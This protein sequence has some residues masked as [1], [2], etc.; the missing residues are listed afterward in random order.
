MEIKA[1]ILIWF[2]IQFSDC[3]VLIKSLLN[4]QTESISRFK[5]SSVAGNSTLSTNSTTTN[6][7]KDINSLVNNLINR[8]Y[9]KDEKQIHF[10]TPRISTDKWIP[11][12]DNNSSSLT[13]ESSN[14]GLIRINEKFEKFDPIL[15]SASDHLLTKNYNG[16][17]REDSVATKKDPQVQYDEHEAL[18]SLNEL[19]KKLKN[20]LELLENHKKIYNQQIP[21]SI[22]TTANNLPANQQQQLQLPPKYPTVQ[23]E[24]LDN[25]ENSFTSFRSLSNENNNSLPHYSL[26]YNQQ[27][28]RIRIN[29]DNHLQDVY[30]KINFTPK[31]YSTP[32]NQANHYS[33]YQN[34]QISSTESYFK[35]LPIESVNLN[36]LIQQQQQQRIAKPAEVFYLEKDEFNSEI[37]PTSILPTLTPAEHQ[38]IQKLTNNNNTISQDHYTN[39]FLPT[40]QPP[41][42]IPTTFATSQ[43]SD[44]HY[45][46]VH[47]HLQSNLISTS[48]LPSTTN[49]QSNQFRNFQNNQLQP[50]LY[51]PIMN[52][53]S[54]PTATPLSYPTVNPL[55]SINTI[56]SNPSFNSILY[57]KQT[58]FPANEFNSRLPFNQGFSS[59]Y[60]TTARTNIP[61]GIQS[62]MQPPNILSSVSSTYL[63]PV[64]NT[65]TIRIPNESFS[66]HPHHLY[67]NTIPNLNNNNNVKILESGSHLNQ[68]NMNPQFLPNKQQQNYAFMDQTIKE[69]DLK[70]ESNPDQI[71]FNLN[72]EDKNNYIILPDPNL[73]NLQSAPVSFRNTHQFNSAISSSPMN[74]LNSNEL[75]NGKLNNNAPLHLMNMKNPSPPTNPDYV[76]VYDEKSNEMYYIKTNDFNHIKSTNPK[77]DL[78]NMH[79]PN[80][81]YYESSEATRELLKAVEA[82]KMAVIKVKPLKSMA[83]RAV[84]DLA[85]KLKD[86]L[87]SFAGSYS[88]FPY[89]DLSE[90]NYNMK[91]DPMR[92]HL[93]FDEYTG[94]MLNSNAMV[95]KESSSLFNTLKTGTYAKPDFLA[96]QND[97]LHL[98]EPISLN[99]DR[100]TVKQNLTFGNYFGSN[101]SY[102]N[103]LSR[104]SIIGNSNQ[105]ANFINNKQ[106]IDHFNRLIDEQ[107]R[108][109]QQKQSINVNP[110]QS[111]TPIFNL[112]TTNSFMKSGGQ[113]KY[114]NKYITKIAIKPNR[115][116]IV[117]HYKYVQSYKQPI[118]SNSEPL[119]ISNNNH[120][121]LN[122]QINYWHSPINEPLSSSTIPL[123]LPRPNPPI[124]KSPNYRYPTTNQPINYHSNNNPNDQ[125]LIV[126]ESKHQVTY[127]TQPSPLSDLNLTDYSLFPN[128]F[129]RL[130][131]FNNDAVNFSQ[132]KKN[133]TS[134]SMMEMRTTK[135]RPIKL[136][137]NA[138][139]RKN[140]TIAN[141]NIIKLPEFNFQYNSRFSPSVK[142]LKKNRNQDKDVTR[143]ERKKVRLR[144]KKENLM[145]EDE[146]E[147]D[148]YLP[149]MQDYSS[150]NN[151]LNQNLLHQFF[152][153]QPTSFNNSSLLSFGEPT[154]AFDA[155]S[156][157]F[158]PFTSSITPTSESN[159]FFD[160]MIDIHNPTATLSNGLS[161]SLS[162]S[163]SNTML[164]NNHHPSIK[165]TIASLP[166]L[167]Q[168]SID[169]LQTG[170]QSSLPFT[171]SSIKTPNLFLTNNEQKLNQVF[172]TN[173]KQGQ[174]INNNQNHQQQ[175]QQKNNSVNKNKLDYKSS[176]TVPLINNLEFL[177]PIKNRL[178]KTFKDVYQRLIDGQKK[179]RNQVNPLNH[180][181]ASSFSSSNDDNEPFFKVLEL[182]E[183]N[184]RDVLNGD[185]DADLLVDLLAEEK[186]QKRFH[187]NSNI[188][189]DEVFG[190][191]KRSLNTGDASMND[192]NLEEKSIELSKE[193]DNEQRQMTDHERIKLKKSVFEDLLRRFYENSENQLKLSK[194]TS[195]DNQTNLSIKN[196][197][198]QSTLAHSIDDS[199]AAD[200]TQSIINNINYKQQ[201]IDY[202]NKESNENGKNRNQFSNLKQHLNES[203]ESNGLKSIIDEN[204]N[205]NESNSRFAKLSALN[206]LFNRTINDDEH[207]PKEKALREKT[208]IEVYERGKKLS[209]FS[210]YYF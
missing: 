83:T 194:L 128:D 33:N 141:S 150:L 189:Q 59:Y 134:K 196:S 5:R 146:E 183:K 82:V 168:S 60:P 125:P 92:T 144:N 119:N 135:T 161:N 78:L 205:K 186:G 89:S 188:V 172:Q 35:N 71:Q 3:S 197:T 112:S 104:Q 63:P 57:P 130:N 210:N 155:P 159:W 136:T 100:N 21:T 118:N 54:F 102:V 2:L 124:N 93:H 162:N 37:I 12:L 13:D 88:S 34:N 177:S 39:T 95:D 84:S 53:N 163:L 193:V 149:K 77:L 49:L 17:R 110:T 73:P 68:L 204:L 203:N 153:E 64:Q 80:K 178:Q 147:K 105:T 31:I 175:Q 26:E 81:D 151:F 202:F 76:K 127:T 139:Q 176:A 170:L 42:D 29:A 90:F 87:K 19:E 70:S 200:S 62:T 209:F 173:N 38:L 195:I 107:K 28:G 18:L 182:N 91:L 133:V 85:S 43:P 165:Y 40:Y 181:Q 55:N 166:I 47:N 65:T 94:K 24:N 179:S 117:Q 75:V 120:T 114:I 23:Y 16:F 167:H 44:D 137:S 160:Q 158:T 67:A 171:Y 51:R 50:Y 6:N 7:L 74:S 61:M 41:I 97:H 157:T 58:E 122:K 14:N 48:N 46:H 126:Q 206:R 9:Q 148:N 11:L 132:N 207:F 20:Q 4:K 152:D 208:Q 201:L 86:H 106:K 69:Y 99:S 121:P 154:L 156:T 45:T 140:N 185:E 96:D 145:M 111:Q 56:N 10:T 169:H 32:A 142:Q 115:P 72:S 138:N 174:L 101:S 22:P 180:R 131:A 103:N 116:P 192:A 113:T 66:S 36:K 187:L 52:K 25:K 108:S 15:T 164:S 98:M 27:P 190:F 198:D 191:N 109:N 79:R 8:S 123:G 184:L 30:A 143:N 1:I 199:T 129:L